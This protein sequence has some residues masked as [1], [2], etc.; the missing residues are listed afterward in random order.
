MDAPSWIYQYTRDQKRPGHDL[1]R[2]YE[3]GKILPRVNWKV[4][5]LTNFSAANASL[6]RDALP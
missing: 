4:Q 1:S 5:E 3:A 6:Q 2:K